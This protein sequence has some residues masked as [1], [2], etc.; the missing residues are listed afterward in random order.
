MW[1]SVL[2][3]AL[4][5]ALDPVRLGVTLLIISRPRARQNLVSYY[6]GGMI[7]SIPALLIPLVLLH[8]TSLFSSFHQNSTTTASNTTTQHIQ[9]GMGTVALS[10]AML[11]VV[12]FAIRQ[13]TSAGR[14]PTA[15]LDANRPSPL[16]RLLARA[17]D[18]TT[19]E[20]SAALRLLGRTHSAWEKGSPWVALVVGIGS[21]PPPFLALFAL[22]AIM[23]SG[24][25]IAEQVSAAIAFVL[26]VLAV[27]EIILVSYLVTPRKT[28]AVMRLLHNWAQNH[29]RSILVTIFAASGVSMMAN[30]LTGV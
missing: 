2:A 21:G 19:Q 20:G 30:G 29:R 24:A 15:M 27:V 14:A 12:R 4:M 3:L 13:R 17:R 9:I 23:S 16:A 26:G 18:A 6:I 1:S 8:C 25:S 28:E 5:T 22:T 10:I 7:V 11:M